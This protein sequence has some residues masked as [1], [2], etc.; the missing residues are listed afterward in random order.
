MV[1]VRIY[2]IIV[3]RS[4]LVKSFNQTSCSSFFPVF[5]IIGKSISE[6]LFNVRIWNL[7]VCNAIITTRLETF[8]QE[9]LKGGVGIPFPEVL[10]RVN[11]SS[12]QQLITLQLGPELCLNFVP[13]LGPNSLV[14]LHALHD[15]ELLAF[16]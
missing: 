3:V 16:T 13:L 2:V 8:N 15:S 12:W 11:R 7:L 5:E 10:H 4:K 14:H 9:V 1:A 6:A